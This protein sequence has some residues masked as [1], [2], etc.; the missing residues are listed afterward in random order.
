MSLV[1]MVCGRH[2]RTP[3]REHP[4][5]AVRATSAQSGRV[6]SIAGLVLQAKRSN[7]AHNKV[8]FSPVHAAARRRRRRNLASAPSPPAVTGAHA[9]ANGVQ[10][11]RPTLLFSG[12]RHLVPW[13]GRG[14][15][16]VVV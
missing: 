5:L 2:C 12:F 11:L 1:V 15:G 7:L 4:M 6:F 14:D 8:N 16:G 13:S 10:T 9:A 3:S